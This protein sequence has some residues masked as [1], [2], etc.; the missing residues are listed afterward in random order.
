MFKRIK[1]WIF[2]VS[3]KT[4][5]SQQIYKK[6][7]VFKRK[8]RFFLN[9]LILFGRKIND[10]NEYEIKVYSQNGEDG[11]LDAIFFKV[12]TLNKFYVEFGVQDGTECN[13]RYL[14]EEKGW[15]GLLMDN[16]GT[17]SGEI[18]KEF[19]SVEN[20]NA[21]FKKYNVPKQFDLLS[22]DIDGN[23]Y[24]VWKA[25]EHAYMPSV[26]TIEYNASIPAIESKVIAYN[27]AHRWDGTNYFG[28]SLAALVKLA[29]L[30]GYTLVGC[31][32]KGVN[33]F[34]VR[35]HLV[36]KNFVTRNIRELYRPPGYGSHNGGH[37]PGKG[38]YVDV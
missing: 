19:I 15:T 38:L 5:I 25:L 34:F 28:A 37:P 23:D 22:I 9:H 11:I 27:P 17:D 8:V 18:K 7:W 33:A 6:L 16:E 1:S 21:L 3:Q 31:D 29:T 36:E 35:N 14:R 26:V 20:I 32:Q 13:T 12:G 4:K 30:K 2:S 24:W 10:L